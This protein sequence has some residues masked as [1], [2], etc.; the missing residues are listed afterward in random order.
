MVP[1][2]NSRIP[3]TI[4]LEKVGRMLVET[5]PVCVTASQTATTRSSGR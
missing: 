1:S 3:A 2:S 5:R 4:T